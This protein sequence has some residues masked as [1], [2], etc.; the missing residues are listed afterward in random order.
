MF[1]RNITLVVDR[2]NLTATYMRARSTRNI[3]ILSISG[4][5]KEPPLI[6]VRQNRL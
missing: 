1:V 6:V 4:A 2:V 5:T 3:F